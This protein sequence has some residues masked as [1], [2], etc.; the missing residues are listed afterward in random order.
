VR[1]D[2]Y[3]FE[4][5]ELTEAIDRLSGDAALGERLEAASRRLGDEPGMARAAE[6]VE[7]LASLPA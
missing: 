2:T 5:E 6:R 4:P 7:A 3:R 1:L